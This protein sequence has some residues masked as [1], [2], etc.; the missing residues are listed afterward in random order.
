[1]KNFAETHSRHTAHRGNERARSIRD[2]CNKDHHMRE[3]RVYERRERRGLGFYETRE[4]GGGYTRG[5]TDRRDE[6]E[7]GAKRDSR[8]QSSKQYGNALFRD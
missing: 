6:R 2:H 4:R 7:E 1:M 3:E 5:E 8:L